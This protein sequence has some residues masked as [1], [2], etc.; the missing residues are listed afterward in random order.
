[1]IQKSTKKDEKKGL[2]SIEKNITKCEKMPYYNYKKLFL[3][4]KTTV[5]LKSNDILKLNKRI[6]FEVINLLQ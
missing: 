2:L 6:F 5:T 3:F 1:M 4:R